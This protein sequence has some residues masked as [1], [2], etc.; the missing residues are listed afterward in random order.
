MCFLF[1][2]PILF[3][4]KLLLQ[5]SSIFIYLCTAHPMARITDNTKNLYILFYLQNNILTF[6]TWDTIQQL[7]TCVILIVLSFACVLWLLRTLFL[8]CLLS[9]IAQTINH[10]TQL[11]LA[12]STITAVVIWDLSYQ[13]WLLC[14]LL[15][16]CIWFFVR[17]SQALP[18]NMSLLP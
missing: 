4:Y 8:S 1:S 17:T 16:R 5:P 7:L 6:L 12:V 15:F 9:N 13:V 11:E 3:H 2:P 14:S 10:W 18:I